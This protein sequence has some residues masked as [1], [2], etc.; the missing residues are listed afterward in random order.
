MRIDFHTQQVIVCFHSLAVRVRSGVVSGAVPGL[1]LMPN[2][3]VL[4]PDLRRL[5]AWH[6][7]QFGG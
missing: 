4:P 1:D 3:F 6:L 5:M 2:S 7:K